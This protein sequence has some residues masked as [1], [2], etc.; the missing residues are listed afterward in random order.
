MKNEELRTK[1]WAA[2]P[3]MLSLVLSVLLWVCV[4]FSGS[5][6]GIV[7]FPLWCGEREVLFFLRRLWKY[8]NSFFILNS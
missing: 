6:A 5:S 2:L 1:N 4:K 7:G 3:P 8:R